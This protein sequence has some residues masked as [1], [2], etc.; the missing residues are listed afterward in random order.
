ML[1]R[2][3]RAD[4]RRGRRKRCR[5]RASPGHDLPGLLHGLLREQSVPGAAERI[6]MARARR[7]LPKQIRIEPRVGDGEEAAGQRMVLPRGE[8]P[9]EGGHAILRLTPLQG[10]CILFRHRVNIKVT[11]GV[12][13]QR[14]VPAGD[15]ES[16]GGMLSAARG[17]VFSGTADG[18]DAGARPPL[19]T[20]TV[21]ETTQTAVRA[22][23][24]SYDDLL[25]DMRARAICTVASLSRRRSG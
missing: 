24:G 17:E 20:Y 12:K 16:G 8:M 13:S 19:I 6:T 7:G 22:G 5:R 14:E 21:P 25:L 4:A 23:G 1:Q 2:S 15:Q 11:F 10:Q 9:F 3:L 18:A